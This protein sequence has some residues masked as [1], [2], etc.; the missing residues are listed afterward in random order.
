MLPAVT[1]R[2]IRVV[3]RRY[4]RRCWWASV[5]DLEQAG[6]IA[7]L[8]ALPSFDPQVGVPLEAYV[9]R[10]V[11]YAMRRAL[12]ADSAPTSGGWHRP[13]LQ[14]TAQRAPLTDSLVP[15]AP[16]PEDEVLEA[17]WSAQ[18]RERL[19]DLG[20]PVLTDL[21]LGR[22][23]HE[24]AAASLGCSRTYLY[25]SLERLRREAGEDSA[26]WHLLKDCGAC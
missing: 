23:T 2:L 5:A 4:A 16:S 20:N 19:N 17:A 1:Q 24:Q 10:A 18:V 9:F 12:W 3:A 11:V 13:E 26:L 8:T 6:W 7:A 21:I 25:R 22:I 15:T 14:R